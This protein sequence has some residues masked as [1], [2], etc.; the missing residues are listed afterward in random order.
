MTSPL[1]LPQALLLLTLQDESGSPKAGFYK[2]AIAGAAISELLLR[3]ALTV[4]DAKKP[5]LLITHSLDSQGAFLDLI[6]AEIAESKKPRDLQSWV[7]RLGN[8]KALVPTLADELCDLGALKKETS[9]LFGV[10]TRST[11]PEASPRLESD[12]KDQLQ[13]AIT[14]DGGIDERLSVMIALADS[15][16]VLRHNFDRALLKTNK[17]RI[18]AIKDGDLLATGA[19]VASVEAARTAIMTTIVAGAVIP[20][21]TAP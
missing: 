17:A 11:W 20:T 12:L 19:T 6:M 1:T 18:K 9:K 16:D 10:F 8:H 14:G 13:A 5:E 3:G 15:A 7:T 4:S 2:P 21:V